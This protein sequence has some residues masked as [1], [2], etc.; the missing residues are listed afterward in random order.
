MTTGHS[1]LNNYRNVIGDKFKSFL[2][3]VIQDFNLKSKNM[4]ITAI[5]DSNI[6][7]Y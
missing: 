4:R 1:I 2:G 7:A 6:K 5:N 3:W